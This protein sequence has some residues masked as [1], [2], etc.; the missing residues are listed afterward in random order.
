MRISNAKGKEDADYFTANP[1][2]I[3]LALAAALLLVVQ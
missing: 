1:G 3:T 2:Q